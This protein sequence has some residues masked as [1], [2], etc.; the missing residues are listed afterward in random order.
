MSS[1]ACDGLHART[2]TA[3]YSVISIVEILLVSILSIRI[4]QKAAYR[5]YRYLIGP[6]YS[7]TI[8]GIASIPGHVTCMVLSI[9]HRVSD[10][11]PWR[12]PLMTPLPPP[13]LR[14]S[15]DDDASLF[16]TA[17]CWC[18]AADGI[19]RVCLAKCPLGYCCVVLH[20]PQAPL[21]PAC[22]QAAQWRPAACQVW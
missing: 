20:V 1:H 12:P 15:F 19:C 7:S 18:L 10:S 8:P 17:A 9:L 5:S 6:I 11:L 2:H 3:G 4:G 21:A 16:S 14:C 22:A 13:S